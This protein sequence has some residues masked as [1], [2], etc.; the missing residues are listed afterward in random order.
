MVHRPNP[1][2]V[3][4]ARFA[5]FKQDIASSYPNFKENAIRSWKEVIEAL[6]EVTSEITK[7]GPDYIPQITFDQ[8]ATLKPEEIE[9]FKRRGAVVIK[10]VVDDQV[11]ESWKAE[12][13]HTIKTDPV[14][15]IPP[16]NSV[17]FE[18]YWSKAQ[19]AARTHPNVMATT[20]W[21]SKLFHTKPGVEVPGGIDLSVQLLY[22]D[23]IRIRSPGY[24]VKML[25]AHVDG[26]T[27]ERW[28]DPKCRSI[29]EDIFAGRWHEHDPYEINA[30]VGANTSMYGRPNQ[31]S[32][33]RTFQGWLSMT[34]T[35][36][37]EGTMKVLPNVHL[38]NAYIILRPFFRPTVALDAAE[39]Y[40]PNSWEF[41]ISTSDF[42]G[43]SEEKGGYHARPTTALHPHLR[44][45]ETVI[46]L[47]KV[48]PGD[49]VFWHC[50]VVHAIE[51][52]HFGKNDSAV[53]YIPAVP[54]TPQNKAYIDQQAKTYL[55]GLRPPDFPQGGPCEKDFT[56][57]AT[58]D[59]FKT[60]AARRGM[61]LSVTEN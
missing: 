39:I 21:L 32:V 36:P 44:M 14:V 15:R 51:F 16:D 12:M 13:E 25:P 56:G 9:R 24:E 55:E 22:S 41:D 6:N 40:D 42:P 8:L 45:N 61:G 2:N 7:A 48:F 11:A 20:T 18:L 59:D 23:R 19:T 46:C 50:D 47:P 33:F 43:V 34:E 10:D 37:K 60:D 54:L 4:P 38:V 26:A 5:L 1:T 29:F 28:E 31:C 53:M 35:G 49:M 3:L 52:E 17:F 30:R 58:V 27:I 57:Y